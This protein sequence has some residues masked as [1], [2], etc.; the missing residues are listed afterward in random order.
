MEVTQDYHHF[1]YTRREHLETKLNKLIRNHPLSGVVMLRPIHNDL[2]AE[3]PPVRPQQ[4]LRMSAEVLN[5][6][7]DMKGSYTPLDAAKALSEVE[8]PDLSEHLFR[9]IP[10]LELSASA[11]KRRVL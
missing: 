10:F 2:H 4:T 1:H 7:N 9:Q 11:M 5:M 3:V 6:L 8:I